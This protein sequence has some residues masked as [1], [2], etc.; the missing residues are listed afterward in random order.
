MSWIR[1]PP[2]S[3]ALREALRVARTTMPREYAVPSDRVPE[4]VRKDSIVYAHARRPD[5]LSGFFSAFNSVFAEGQALSRREQEL[6]ACVVS[7][8]NDCFY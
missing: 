8:A 2:S 1:P 3:D 6:V 5:A 7:R 4:A